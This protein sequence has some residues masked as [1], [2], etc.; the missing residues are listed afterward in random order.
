M[1]VDLIPAALAAGGGSLLM[2]GILAYEH[3]REQAMRASRV[4]L[5]LRFPAG[6]D[7]SAVRAALDALAGLDLRMEL[8]AAIVASGGEVAHHLLVPARVERS[9]A[10]A[11]A[12]AVPGV[13]L[14]PAEAP[15]GEAVAGMRLRVPVD[16]VL[17]SDDEVASVRALLSGLALL[18]R[19]E[20]VAL[21]WALRPTPA[22]TAAEDVEG[23]PGELVRRLRAKRLEPGFDAAGLLLVRASTRGRARQLLAQVHDVIRARRSGMMGVRGDL[24]RRSGQM[25][26][27]PQTGRRSG[28]LS[29]GE[30]AALIAWPVGDQAIPGVQVGAARELL[31]PRQV[32]HRG[33]RLLVG[34]DVHGER[35]V[36]MDAA[37]ATHHLSLLGPT[38]SGKS[39]LLANVVLD[40]LAA[41]FGGVLIDPKSDL[42]E[43]ILD[44][45]PAEHADRVVVLDPAAAG[46]VP[47]LDLFGTGDAELRS[48]VLLS[49]LRNL[50]AGWGPRIEQFMKLGLRTAAELPN[51]VLS[52]W[53]RLYSEPGLRR[54]AVGRL[55]PIRQGQW[56]AY[57]AMTPA[58]QQEYV[59]PATSRIAGLLARPAVRAVL[60]QP[61]PKLDI[62]RLLAERKLLLVNLAPGTLGEPA[63][64]LLGAIV[65]YLTWSA[66]E[67][68]VAIPAE[69]RHP[70][71]LYLDELQ[72]LS[73][74]PI[75]LELFF[76]RTRGLGCGVV[77]ATQAL[78]RLPESARAS[79]L[80]NTG[81]LVSFTAG[82]DEAARIARELP[83]LD[84]RDITG[85]GRFEVAARLHTST[86]SVVLTGHTEP[87]PPPAGHATAIR[88][89]SA[90]RYGVDPAEVE[91]EL[92]RRLHRDRDPDRAVGRTGRRS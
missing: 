34:R 62:A 11:L 15:S 90:A 75:G 50:S 7:P 65:A 69:R 44:R 5:G 48:D 35:P 70:V 73:A 52:D 78:A 51:P 66:I 20:T 64:R 22:P 56:A 21:S 3:R 39:V 67:A 23:R 8:V 37:S 79:L 6:V 26:A 32:P 41:G 17:R 80:G 54:A 25:D 18:G 12:A 2:G 24:L 86:G 16:V 40:D 58:A 10:T 82:A 72:S 81:S 31:V 60:N 76:E 55:D 83:G 74:L 46:S 68:R 87:L 85:L 91:A 57:E 13:R 84:A 43:T 61:A 59:A 49:V 29:V 14:Q 36:A 42:I 9:A 38:G 92:A 28:W 53:L 45:V 89:M 47:G 77:V 33:R 4:R 27:L 88:A 19:G 63:A 71:F 1:N 30:L